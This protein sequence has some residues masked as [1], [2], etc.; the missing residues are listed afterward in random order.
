M[1]IERRREDAVCME[2]SAQKML[3]DLRAE[4]LRERHEGQETVADT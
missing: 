2:L 1:S 4:D 3:A